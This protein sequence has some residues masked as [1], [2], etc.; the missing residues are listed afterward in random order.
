MYC[1]S[2][3]SYLGKGESL[4]GFIFCLKFMPGPNFDEDQGG[5]RRES[6]E[7]GWRHIF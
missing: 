2:M 5:D 4:M 7:L 6:Q 3:Y 1:T